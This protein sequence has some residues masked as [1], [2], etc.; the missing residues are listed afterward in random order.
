MKLPAIDLAEQRW[1]SMKTAP[2][3]YQNEWNFRNFLWK[4]EKFKF[5]KLEKSC[6]DLLTKLIKLVTS[7]DLE[8]S[9]KWAYSRRSFDGSDVFRR[10]SLFFCILFVSLLLYASL[11]QFSMLAGWPERALIAHGSQWVPKWTTAFFL[12]LSRYRRLRYSRERAF[13]ICWK[14]FTEMR[15]HAQAG[16]RIALVSIVR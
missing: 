11:S 6:E 14:S 9:W 8:T 15:S 10:S 1:D 2:K 16:A 13:E 3:N 7:V 5:P 12:C 4:I